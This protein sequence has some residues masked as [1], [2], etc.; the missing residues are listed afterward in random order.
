[1]IPPDITGPSAAGEHFLTTAAE[2]LLILTLRS[3]APA[4][5]FFYGPI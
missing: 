1:M 4:A 2:R 3:G 5:P